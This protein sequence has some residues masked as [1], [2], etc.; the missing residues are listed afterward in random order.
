MAKLVHLRL[1]EQLL[2]ESERVVEEGGY[3]TMS[4]FIK[5]SM[6][7]S[8]DEYK[9]RKALYMLE[10]NLGR[11]RGKV[12][13]ITENERAEIAKEFIGAGGSDAFGKY[14]LK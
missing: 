14:G 13:Q 9:R 11:G 7:K 6:R 4:E 1:P 10:K 3:S 5:E 12:R 2:A 8:I